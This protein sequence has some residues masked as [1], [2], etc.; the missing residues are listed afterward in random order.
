M[1]G[2]KSCN[3]IITENLYY[4]TFGHYKRAIEN[5][6]PPLYSGVNNS[7]NNN[8]KEGNTLMKQIEA[9]H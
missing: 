8:Y 5:I 4:S 7:G 9:E 6:K 3:I 1:P 2:K